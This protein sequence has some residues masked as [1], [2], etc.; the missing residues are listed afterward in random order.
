MPRVGLPFMTGHFIEYPRYLGE[1]GE[2]MAHRDF[3][4][5]A[6]RMIAP[7]LEVSRSGFY[8]AFLRRSA[9]GWSVGKR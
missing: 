1:I 9:G 5:N 4:R 7:G 2:I 6:I 8:G 3:L